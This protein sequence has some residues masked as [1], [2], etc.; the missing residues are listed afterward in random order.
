[1]LGIDVKL[2]IDVKKVNMPVYFPGKNVCTHCGATDSLLFVDKFGRESRKEINAFDHIICKKCNRLYSIRWDSD[3]NGN[4]VPSAVNPSISRDLNNLFN[5]N[6]IKN[7]GD[8][9]LN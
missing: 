4:M 7:N 5:I 3:N 6:S 2:D 9:I 1:M 8:K